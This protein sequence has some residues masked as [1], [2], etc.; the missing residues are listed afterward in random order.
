MFFQFPVIYTKNHLRHPVRTYAVNPKGGQLNREPLYQTMGD[1]DDDVDMAVI[2]VRAEFV[3]RVIEQCIHKGVKGAV[4]ISG[5]FS[6]SGNHDLQQRVVDIAREADFPF[7]GPN[8]L[9]IYAPDIVDTFFL[10]G[11]RIIRPKK[12]NIGFVSQSGGVLVDQMVKFSGQ[13]IGVSLAVSIGNKAFLRETDMID[14]FEKDLQTRVIAFYIEGFEAREG[15]E[16]IKQ[17]EVC[18]KPIIVLKAGKSMKGIEAV[19][20]HTASLA[21]D[22]R[23]FSEVMKQHCVAEA[24]N[25]YELTSFCESLSCYPKGIHGN[26]GIVSLSGGHGVMAADACSAQGMNIPG[27]SPETVKNIRGKLSS[28]IMEIAT[29]SNP[30]DLTGSCVDCDIMTSVR[31]LARDENIDCIL[32]L[33]LPYSPGISADIGASLS[34]VAR[35]E[36]KP[37]IAYVPNEDKY[38]I[39]IEGFELNNIPVASSVEGAVLMAKALN[40]CRPC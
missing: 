36:G 4:I 30:L 6:E 33:L 17:A 16:F 11:E 8:C 25:E 27:I 23:T 24:E 1:I 21:G 28:E 9:G 40:R 13:G 22:Y 18:S 5:G 29:L 38:K 10:P 26:V 32:A 20:S 15:R 3:P 7:V 12:G 2:A 35:N 39:I 14:W 37:M 19:S 31:Y 34:Q